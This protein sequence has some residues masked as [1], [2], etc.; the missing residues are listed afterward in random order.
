MKKFTFIFILFMASGF[1][2]GQFSIGPKIGF[3]TS[4]LTTDLD[5]IESDASSNFNFG[6]FVRLG[7][8]IY[9]QPEINWLTSGGVYKKP[10]IGDVKP[11]KQE[12]EMKSIEIPL[13]VGWRIINLGVG[14]IRVLAGPSASIITNSTV[15][16]SDVDNFINPIKESDIEDMLW[17][18]NIGAGADILMFTLDIRYQMG[19]NEVIKEVEG[20]SFNS[21]NNMFAVSLGWK[22]L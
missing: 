21:K 11:I 19:L 16:T 3:N 20:F 14:N 6:V 15:S 18:F 10:Q 22:I 7:S 9:L 2:F 17:G 8:K 12:V 1:A 4:K 5:Q 13:I